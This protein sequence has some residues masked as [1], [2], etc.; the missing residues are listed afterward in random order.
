[1]SHVTDEESSFSHLITITKSMGWT[2]QKNHVAKQKA[3]LKR[4]D[5]SKTL[6]KSNLN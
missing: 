6:Y 2:I 3:N 1:M 4:Y 5:V